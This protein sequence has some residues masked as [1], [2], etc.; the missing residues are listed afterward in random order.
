MIHSSARRA[1]LQALRTW[2]TQ[3]QLA[4][5]VLSSVLT[6]SV[7][8]AS[9]RGFAQELFY[10][11][12]RNLTL[13]DFWINQLRS[14]RLNDDLRDIVRLGL[15]Q[16]FLLGVLNA[17]FPDLINEAGRQRLP[18]CVQGRVFRYHDQTD[19]AAV[20]VRPCGCRGHAVADFF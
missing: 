16:L 17:V 18:D 3:N 9:D 20:T 11:V 19:R 14:S 1:A 4:D 5:A 15:Y 6:G 13:L 8:G 12:L 7:L 2:R 10:G